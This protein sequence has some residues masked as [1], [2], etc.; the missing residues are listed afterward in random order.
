MGGRLLKRWLA[1]PLK[2]VGK[3]KQRH[4]VVSY[5]LDDGVS[6]DKIRNNIK[7]IGDIERLISKVATQR[8]SPREVIQLK[9]SLE[10][11]VPI[12]ALA[13]NCEND[14]LKGIGDNLH[15]CDLLRNK[16]KETLN[17][18]S[19]V[20]ILKGNA[21]ATGVNSELDEYRGLAYSGKDYLNKML[22]RET[23]ATGISSL[24]IASNN[25]FRLN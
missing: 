7:Q 16:I 20:N 10:A 21:I 18:D 2:N 11:I 8:I 14:A 13:N 25:V 5:L 6:F 12:K 22:A 19:P 1:F 9:N 3:I 23:E 15:G 24:K 4:Q 17:E